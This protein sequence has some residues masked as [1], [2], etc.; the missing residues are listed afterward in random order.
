MSITSEPPDPTAL[1]APILN[2]VRAL[3]AARVVS[4]L[5]EA[6]VRHG[7]DATVDAVVFPALR[8]IGTFWASGTLDVAHERVLSN[9][10]T[11]WVHAQLE[12]QVLHRHG[13]VLLTAGPEDLHTVGL[14]CLELL[15]AHRGVEVCNLGG[16]VPTSSLAVAA[17][18]TRPKAVVV[19]SHTPTATTAAVEAVSTA[20]EGG[21]P[22]YYAGATFQSQFVRRHVL[23][24][25]LDGTVGEAAEMLTRLHTVV[26]P[27]TASEG[28]AVRPTRPLERIRNRW[29][30]EGSQRPL[31]S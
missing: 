7:L 5:D 9:G 14:D 31:T 16:Q 15:L 19:C 20:V 30:L 8:V 25:P 26:P 4:V 1:V 10:I 28:L 21:Y 24:R 27:T 11:R 23:G 17:A 13:R 29:S 6:A 3:N 22:T 18:A 12:S 2:A